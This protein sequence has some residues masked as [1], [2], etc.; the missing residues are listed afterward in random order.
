[1]AKSVSSNPLACAVLLSLAALGVAAGVFYGTQNAAGRI[2]GA[3]SPQKM[4][5][6]VY[7]LA[8]W[9]VIPLA[10]ALDRRGSVCLRQAF[11]A[12]FALMLLRAPVE[13]WMLYVSRNWSP[14]YGIAHDLVCTGVLLIF[15]LQ[16]WRG[17]LW[18]TAPNGWLAVHLAVTTAAF[19][20]EIYFAH[21]MTRHFVTAGD[22]AIYFVPADARYS[23]VLR[24]TAVVVVGLSLY[25]PLFLWGWLFG[26]SGS[27]RTQPR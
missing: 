20:A 8:L 21:Y 13:L 9:G 11:G 5:W 3:I 14:W 17:R 2:G 1:M 12:L 22:A 24:V 15:M 25:L 27:K 19:A 16:A 23:E 18:R 6:L 10:I 7:A 4:M 26:A